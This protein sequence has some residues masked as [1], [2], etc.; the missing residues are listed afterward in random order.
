MTAAALDSLPE[1]NPALDLLMI[2]AGQLAE[3][4]QNG[5]IG[6]IEAVDLAY[7]AAIWAGLVDKYG[8]DVVQ[9]ILADAFIGV[10]KE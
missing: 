4:A 6:F 3:L 1:I 2:R 9:T 5:S 10:R 7:S 8:N